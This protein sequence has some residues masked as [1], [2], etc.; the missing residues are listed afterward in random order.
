MRLFDP[1]DLA[2][3][4]LRDTALFNETVNLQRESCFQKILFGM[5]Q[6]EVGENIPAALFYTDSQTGTLFR[7]CGHVS[8]AFP[9]EAGLP[10]L[11]AGG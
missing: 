7:S 3:F 9:G 8:F 5:G 4:S 6:T 2:G 1:Q 11:A 10:H